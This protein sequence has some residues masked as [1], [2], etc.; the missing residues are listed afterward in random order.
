[1]S[2][3]DR[4]MEKPWSFPLALA[5]L[6]LLAHSLQI[7]QPGFF[8]DDWQVLLLARQGGAGAFW[9]YFLSDR[10]LSI[11][12]YLISVPLLGNSALAWQIYSLALRWAVIMCLTHTLRVVFP[13]QAGLARAAG[14]LLAVYPGF[15][16]QAISVAYSQH[17]TALALFSAS[18]ALMAEAQHGPDRRRRLYSFVAALLAAV[19]MLTIEYFVGLEA[20]RPLLLWI[21]LR[22]PAE[23]AAQT[24]RRVLRRWWPYLL[25]GAAFFAFRFFLYPALFPQYE[26]NPPILIENL[27]ASPLPALLR[28]VELVLQDG[29]FAV[30]FA[31]LN[32]FDPTALNLDA[33]MTWFSW[34]VG[35]LA[36]AGVFFYLRGQPTD[37][38][39]A[40]RDWPGWLALG[41]LALLSGGLPVW[42]TNRQ[43]IAGAFSD[44]FT[45]GM[46]FGAV[47]L[48][49][50]GVQWLSASQRR[51]NLVF[52]VLVA[53]GVAAQ[54]REL[55]HYRL[56]WEMQRRYTWQLLWRAPSLPPGS[57]VIGPVLPYGYSG[58]YSVAF[59]TN[60]V[61]AGALNSDALPYWW[62]NG[63]RAWSPEQIKGKKPASALKAQFRNLTFDST[64]SQS[65]PVAYNPA[66]GCLLV[67]DPVYAAG[68]PLNAETNFYAW[69]NPAHPA[70]EAGYNAEFVRQVFGEAPQGEWC[71]YFEQADLARAYA[72]WPAVLRLWQEAQQQKLAPQQAREFVPF[73]QA[74][75]ASGDFESARQL[76]R[77]ALALDEQAAPL[78]CGLW[79]A[80]PAAEKPA[81]PCLP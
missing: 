59:Y 39:A 58:D 8:W 60:L 66:G 55:N 63:T 3:F 19:H 16:Q 65:L 76:S 62:F 34:G 22:Q 81:L 61:Y 77:D 54:T 31:W 64:V 80:A 43:A 78:L 47:L 70:R 27:L 74:F 11:W 1:M 17:W 29:L 50:T 15:T 25:A 32:P 12:T 49:A 57:A 23:P 28:L 68:T 6:M 18:L 48:L 46:M 44:R 35:L 56:H 5:S 41:G 7:W 53:G 4:W 36:G 2:R 10:P 71:Q 37:E 75:L 79:Q 67:L 24:A 38:T 51:W 73:L 26:P 14:F 52:A 33:K 21:L 13:R 69:A 42:S 9:N 45:L 40:R 20:A 72:D 30:I